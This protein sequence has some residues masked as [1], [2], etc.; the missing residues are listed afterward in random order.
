ML[1]PQLCL[2]HLFFPLNKH[3]LDL[4]AVRNVGRPFGEIIVTGLLSAIDLNRSGE[5]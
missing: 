4:A 1:V 3:I 2:H 5:A